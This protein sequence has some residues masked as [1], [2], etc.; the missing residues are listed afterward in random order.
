MNIA[1]VRILIALKIKSEREKA[2]TRDKLCVVPMDVILE[3]TNSDMAT[4][5][6]STVFKNSKVTRAMQGIVALSILGNSKDL[7]LP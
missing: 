7:I 1:Y 2:L 3:S 5:F 6:F 4:L